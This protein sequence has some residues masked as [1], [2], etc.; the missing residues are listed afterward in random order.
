MLSNFNLIPMV[1]EESYREGPKN[2]MIEINVIELYQNQSHEFDK[3][4]KLFQTEHDF[5]LI[6]VN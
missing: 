6:G 4:G 5:K 1:T 2:S 3:T